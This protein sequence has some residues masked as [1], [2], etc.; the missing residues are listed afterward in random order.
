VNHKTY[1]YV[2][3]A[4]AYNQFKEYNPED[5]TLLDGQRKPYISSRLNFDGTAI[6]STPAVPHTPI[7]EAGGTLQ[8]IE[9]GSSPRITRLDGFGNGNRALELTQEST[10]EIL[11]TGFMSAPTYDYGKG[12]INIKVVDPLNL[13]SGYFECKFRD[14]SAPNIGN[15]ADTASWVIYRYSSED[16]IV[17]LDSVTSQRTIDF[18]NEQI[19]P[20]WGISV[21]INQSKYFVPEGGSSGGPETKTTT[22]ISSSINFA[23]SSKQWLTGVKDNDAYFPTNWIVC[24]E[25]DPDEDADCLDDGPSY[26]N[27]CNYQD[28]ITKDQSSVWEGILEGIVAPH[29]LVG[30]EAD[31]A[32]MS[33]LG[34]A[35]TVRKNAPISFA[36]SVDIVFTSNQDLWTRC[37]VLETGRDAG[38]NIGQ[39]EAG[40]LRR[41]PSVDKE[42]NQIFPGEGFAQSYGMGW[43]PGYAIDLETG[44]RL[45]MAF[46]ENSFLGGENGAD[47]IW[48][49]TSNLVSNVG[50]PLM[51]GVHP[52]YVYSKDIKKLNGYGQSY[53][54]PEYKPNEAIYDN[55]N[56]LKLLLDLAE[57]SPNLTNCRKAYAPLTWI[58]YP[59]LKEGQE[60]LSTDVTIKLRIN[61]EYKDYVATGA[62]DGKPMY[63]WSMDDIATVT[64]S[65]DQ[66]KEALD[67]INIVPNPYYAFSEYERSRLETKV[68]ITNLPEQCT[69]KIYTVNGKLVRTFK[70][71]SPITSLDW[72]LTN[73]KAIPVSSG[74]YLIHVSVPNVG[75]RVLK[76]FGGM[77]QVDLQGI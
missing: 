13:A 59:M 1:Y 41:S 48:N 56:Q 55:L 17:P 7:P 71:D 63:S 35:S 69:V 5:P 18:D 54:F 47:M 4:Y 12:P 30:Y 44:A 42:G 67:I 16:D 57:L 22:M 29:Q 15:S 68:K 19:V 38:L 52:I 74:I 25:Y 77:R 53:D 2:A 37:P 9:Y 32:P 66:L 20:E 31:Y 45:Y 46:G 70:K 23:D 6:S 28:E 65:Q 33:Y 36:P 27:P 14:Y 61:K 62:N 58:C 26:L 72:D 21:Q 51:G 76:F 39:A 43:F 64:A 49:P 10:D 50:T 40:Q 60:L 75:E 3:V 73:F 8:L 24:G 11:S 34:S